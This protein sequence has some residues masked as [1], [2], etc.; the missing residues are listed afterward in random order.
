MKVPIID[1]ISCQILYGSQV[2][3]T[4]RHIC[5]YDPSGLKRSCDR[6][7]GDALVVNEKLVGVMSYR[8]NSPT[9]GNPQVFMNLVD[10]EINSWIQATMKRLQHS[11]CT[12]RFCAKF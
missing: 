3:I 2:Q 8:E 6:D 9:A 11:S 4:D 1:N 7:G 12:F 10:P 5:T